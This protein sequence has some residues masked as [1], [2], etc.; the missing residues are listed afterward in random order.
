MKNLVIKMTKG[1][2][3]NCGMYWM[4]FTTYKNYHI[5]VEKFGYKDDKGMS[6]EFGM[7]WKYILQ[8]L[9]SENIS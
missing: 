8:L 9:T 6:P 3:Q 2:H 5:Y 7:H 1:C 4:Y